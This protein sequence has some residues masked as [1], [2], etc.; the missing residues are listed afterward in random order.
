M[1]QARSL[2]AQF[3]TEAV[4]L[5]WLVFDLA[6]NCWTSPIFSGR[7]ITD[8][9]LAAVAAFLLYRRY[10]LITRPLD[11][12]MRLLP[13]IQKDDAAIEDL[14]SIDGQLAPLAAQI[15]QILQELREERKRLDHEVRQ[16]I[17]NRTSAL[18][19][20]IGSLRQQ[21]SRDILTGLLN[22][23]LFDE[24]IQQAIDRAKSSGSNLSLLMID[25][26]N[27][28]VLNDTLGHQAGD[29]LL[30]SIGQLIRSAIRESDVA[31]RY[32]GDEFAILI[33]NGNA[34]DAHTLASRLIDLVDS[35]G[36]TYKL[37]KS[38]GLSAGVAH[39]NELTDITT[40]AIISVADKALYKLKAERR[41]G[42][43]KAIPRPNA[44]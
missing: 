30:R 44:A 41:A 7:L 14:A 27:F 9:N 32:G 16:R 37:A 36:K 5:A 24:Y 4:L 25:V 22:R 26:D 13:A 38:P 35:L 17:A 1:R 34:D 19:R 2:A 18:E 43:L 12:L 11:K 21:A 28:K 10:R 42:S 33:E 3:L 8:V 40:V 39:V 15:Q 31:F 29:E 23:R 6:A 20:T